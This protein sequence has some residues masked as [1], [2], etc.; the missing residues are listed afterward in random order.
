MSLKV[1]TICLILQTPWVKRIWNKCPLYFFQ[2]T[3]RQPNWLGNTDT[4]NWKT[5]P[6]AHVNIPQAVHL[7]KIHQPTKTR[8]KIRIFCDD[9]KR[10]ESTKLTVLSWPGLESPVSH[11]WTLD[12]TFRTPA[13]LLYKRANTGGKWLCHCQIVNYH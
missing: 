9:L 5:W 10:Q 8:M 1:V 6:T 7:R 11:E 3:K 13:F 2:I 4:L 12:P